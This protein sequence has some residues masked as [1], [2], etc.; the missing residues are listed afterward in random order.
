MQFNNM[1]S[2]IRAFRNK[3][4]ITLVELAGRLQVSIAY[5]SQ[6]ENGKKNLSKAR[7]DLLREMFTAYN[8]DIE[9][10]DNAF[11]TEAKLFRTSMLPPVL[12][13]V[14]YRLIESNMTD[15]E[16]LKLEKVI[17]ESSHVN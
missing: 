6:V 1:A 2:L 13:R 16:L 11:Y 12:R 5:I 3:H 8:E 7:V 9:E 4:G 14:I 17:L 15:D 10:L